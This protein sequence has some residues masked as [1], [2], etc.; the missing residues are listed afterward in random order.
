MLEALAIT[1]F[2]VTPAKV[3]V[4]KYLESLERGCME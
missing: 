4:Q 3:G 1:R 2:C